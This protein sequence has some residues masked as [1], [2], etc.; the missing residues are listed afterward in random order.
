LSTTTCQAF[1]VA[2]EHPP[3]LP[4][5]PPPNYRGIGDDVILPTAATWP[6]D[7]LSTTT[8]WPRGSIEND[9]SSFDFVQR[10]LSWNGGVAPMR[11]DAFEAFDITAGGYSLPGEVDSWREGQTGLKL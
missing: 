2:A 1:L 5:P 10:D 11:C 8:T 4:P 9:A 3:D 6:C 7:V